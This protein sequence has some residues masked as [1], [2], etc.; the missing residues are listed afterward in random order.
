MYKRSSYDGWLPR[1]PTETDIWS[2]VAGAVRV[3]STRPMAVNNI[4]HK[5]ANLEDRPTE[6]LSTN[7]EL[8]T[9][10]L[11]DE[12]LQRLSMDILYPRCHSDRSGGQTQTRGSEELKEE[13]RGAA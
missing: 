3:R 5:E 6:S 13:A 1:S 9:H 12:T 7:P 2:R 11:L 10:L 8:L 4:P